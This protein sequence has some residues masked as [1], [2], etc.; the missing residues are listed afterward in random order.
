MAL[1]FNSILNTKTSDI[2]EPQPLPVGT[3]LLMIDGYPEFPPDGVGKK[4]TPAANLTCKYIAAQSDVDPRD[5]AEAGGLEGK[6]IRHTLWL[7]KDAL[8]MVI[9]FARDTLG[10]DVENKTLKQIFSEFPNK[11]FYAQIGHRPSADG[12]R[13]FNDIK[14][15]SA[16]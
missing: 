4:E 9:R 12:T 7:S 13:L 1:D 15:T 16:V 6:T 2:K 11:Q 5:V 10:I 14:S 8:A 3:Y